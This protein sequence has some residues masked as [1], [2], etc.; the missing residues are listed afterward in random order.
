MEKKVF[1]ILGL[2]FLIAFS[3]FL[4]GEQQMGQTQVEEEIPVG[5][6][7]K[8]NTPVLDFGVLEPGMVASRRLEVTNTGQGILNWKAIHGRK[9]EKLPFYISLLNP[10]SR[11]KGH[12]TVPTPYKDAVELTGVIAEK[13]GWP[14]LAAQQVVRFSFYGTGVIVHYWRMPEG[15]RFSF[16]CDQ[17]WLGEV[18]TQS[19]KQER[20][21]VHCVEHLPPGKHTLTVVGENGKTVLA[22]FEVT[23]RDVQWSPKH[24]RF[25]PDNGVT[26]KEVD[27]VT[28]TVDPQNAPSGL[29]GHV[30]S[31]RSN[32]GNV[33]VTLSWEVKNEGSPKVIDVFR[34]ISPRETFLFT[35]NPQEDEKIIRRGN[36]RKEGVSFRLFSHGT[37]GT[38]EFYR[39]YNPARD[40]FFYSYNKKDVE[41]IERGFVMEGSVGNI[42]TT[43]LRNTR[44]LY[45]WFN[46]KTGHYFYTPLVKDP[47]LPRGYRFD[48]IAGYIPY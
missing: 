31:F 8:I 19:E 20:T 23:G 37:P 13:N 2:G 36:Y 48:G 32:G 39:W 35:T 4:Y 28:V 3:T 1:I 44:E 38:M 45:R 15:G 43:R 29:Y 26:T 6:Q 10:E 16:L 40:S 27:Y 24:V 25:I 46:P 30:I 7:I 5:P 34:Y 33:D 12:Y 9:I 47:S 22:G 11:G 42:A 14:V 21:W 17:Y 18:D 41:K